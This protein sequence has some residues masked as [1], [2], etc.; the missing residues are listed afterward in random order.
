MDDYGWWSKSQTADGIAY[1]CLHSCEVD[2]GVGVPDPRRILRSLFLALG[3]LVVAACQAAPD[4][5]QVEQGLT[6]VP[7]L[8]PY[9]SNTFNSTQVGQTSNTLAFGVRTTSSNSYLTITAISYSCPDYTVTGTLPG[10]AERDCTT[11]CPQAANAPSLQCPVASPN[12]PPPPICSNYDYS[13]SAV[14][15]PSLAAATSCVVTIVTDAGNLGLTLYGTGTAPPIH[16][17]ASPGSVNYGGVRINTGSSAV[18]ISVVNSGGATATIN[19]VTTS[20]G[21]TVSGNTGAHTLAAGTGEGY[22][23]VC[24]PTAVGPLDGSVNISSNDPTAPNISIPLACSGIDSVLAISPSPAT[25][26]TIR[27]GES[28]M[29]TLS[30]TNMGAADTSIQGVT[31][32]GM[33]M[34]SAPASGTLLPA[35]GGSASVTISFAGQTAGSTSGTLHVDYDNGKS[36]DTQITAKAVATSLSLTPDGDVDLGPICIGQTKSQDFAMIGTDEGSFKLT[37]V[38]TLAAPF[39]L[40]TPTLPATVQGAAANRVKLTVAGAPTT[41]GDITASFMFDTDIP[42]GT[43]HTINLHMLG[44]TEGVN[45]PPSVDLGGNLVNQTSLGQHVE[46]SNCTAAPVT[47]TSVNISGTDA[48]DFTLVDQPTE[49]TIM[50]AASIKWLVILDPH[51]TGEKAAV[52]NALFDGGTTAVPLI[53]EGLGSG[54][55]SGDGGDGSKSSYYACNTGS[56][57][58][59]APIGIA[60]GALVLR[61]RRRA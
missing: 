59:L 39:T 41:D 16:V 21:F 40:T 8:L 37:S 50:P 9:P 26:P 54:V 17:T 47:I 60:L 31:V 51:S 19:S 15:H 2:L 57:V 46:I 55:G 36:I 28:E 10:Y 34:V 4:T 3:V 35:S 25:L 27:V 11:T 20:A 49:L 48:A 29:Q 7:E 44:L 33:T 1:S 56:P 43:A 5:G 12:T 14:F 23:V 22:S 58:G 45:G 61:R 13:F 53:G 24:H 52:F 42:M 18:P 38:S 32:T 30:I 6:A